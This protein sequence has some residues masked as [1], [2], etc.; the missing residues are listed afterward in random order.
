MR[1]SWLKKSILGPSWKHL[2]TFW[3]HLKA[4]WGHLGGSWG[5][6]GTIWSPKE[7][8]M[9]HPGKSL[10]HLGD[11]LEHLGRS[12]GHLGASWVI[13]EPSWGHLE[14]FKRHLEGILS[15]SWSHMLKILKNHCF[16]LVFQWFSVAPSRPKPEVC[17]AGYTLTSFESCRRNSN[18]LKLLSVTW[19]ASERKAGSFD[20]IVHECPYQFDACLIW[21]LASFKPS[22]GFD[23]MCNYADDFGNSLLFILLEKEFAL[24]LIVD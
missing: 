17:G 19:A 23:D 11:I 21:F 13:L 24:H 7:V 6:L 18:Q 12:C 3:S 4:I 8:E 5:H 1:P 20:W 2:G 14:G 22:R 15:P 10:G 16:S 9:M